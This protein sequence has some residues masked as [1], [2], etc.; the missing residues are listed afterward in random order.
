MDVT[1]KH[2]WFLKI[3]NVALYQERTIL[4]VSKFQYTQCIGARHGIHL[5]D[6]LISN[7]VLGGTLWLRLNMETSKSAVLLAN[8]HQS[9][10]KKML[11]MILV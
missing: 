4:I 5:S 9:D 6:I 10:Q 2:A 3:R 7:D 1:L 11:Q 8:E